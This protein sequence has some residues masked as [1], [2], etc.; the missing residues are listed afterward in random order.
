MC[1]YVHVRFCQL[2]AFCSCVWL[3]QPPNPP[4]GV[5]GPAFKWC[6]LLLPACICWKTC[7]KAL[8]KLCISP[9]LESLYNWT[10]WEI[11]YGVEILPYEQVAIIAWPLRIW[12]VKCSCLSVSDIQCTCMMSTEIW[13][14]C[15]QP[16]L[17]DFY[18]AMTGLLFGGKGKIRLLAEKLPRKSNRTMW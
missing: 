16:E 10:N 6:I 7:L 8:R 11:S 15:W 3:G 12:P 9:D 2:L 18:T 13:H 17:I 4:V 14:V 5:T 1:T